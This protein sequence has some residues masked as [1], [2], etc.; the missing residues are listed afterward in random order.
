MSVRGQR[1]PLWTWG[2][3]QSSEKAKKQANEQASKM[4]EFMSVAAP[5]SVPEAGDGESQRLLQNP[6]VSR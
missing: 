5:E 6:E 4:H 2:E 3:M 1:M